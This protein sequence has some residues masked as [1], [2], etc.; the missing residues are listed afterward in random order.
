MDVYFLTKH[1]TPWHQWMH[2]NLWF[3]STRGLNTLYLKW[4]LLTTSSCFHEPPFHCKILGGFCRDIHVPPHS[5][6]TTS[7]GWGSGSHS[8]EKNIS[9][10]LDV[11]MM[12]SWHQEVSEHNVT[13]HSTKKTYKSKLMTSQ[14]YH[15][16]QNH[17]PSVVHILWKCFQ[18]VLRFYI[19]KTD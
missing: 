7:S 12:S 16:M 10:G 5:F 3:L 11:N 17:D 8:R 9:R 13:G 2:T 18:T 1:R 4:L 6:K 14:F 15:L 19:K